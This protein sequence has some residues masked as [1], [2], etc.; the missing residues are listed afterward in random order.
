[1]YVHD[2]VYADVPLIQT[3]IQMKQ[4]LDVCVCVQKYAGVD[5]PTA[6]VYLGSLY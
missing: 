2:L 3:N 5:I 4:N 6:A 1:M